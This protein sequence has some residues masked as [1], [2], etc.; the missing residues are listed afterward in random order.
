M[1]VRCAG[2]PDEPYPYRMIRRYGVRNYE[3]EGGP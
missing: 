3:S 1:I 2:A